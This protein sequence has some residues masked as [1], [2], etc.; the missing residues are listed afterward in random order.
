MSHSQPAAHRHTAQPLSSTSQ[1]LT[2]DTCSSGSSG[3][4]N[5][6]AMWSGSRMLDTICK[7]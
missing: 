3:D 1:P 4:T 6:S 7:Q 2:R 5:A